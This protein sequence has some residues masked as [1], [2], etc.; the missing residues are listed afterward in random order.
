MPKISLKTIV[1]IILILLLALFVFIITLFIPRAEITYNCDG[2][3]IYKMVTPLPSNV[4]LFSVDKQSNFDGYSIFKRKSLI[5]YTSDD[6]ITQNKMI[7]DMKKINNCKNF[8]Y[9][10]IHSTIISSEVSYCYLLNRTGETDYSE[11]SPE[12][13]A[14]FELK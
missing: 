14:K 7:Q 6:Q 12:I 10:A 3:N 5:F 1:S 8:N 9:N 2:Y 11:C 4:I 13:K